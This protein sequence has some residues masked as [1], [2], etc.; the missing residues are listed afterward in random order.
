MGRRKIPRV[1]QLLSEGTY[2]GW[3]SLHSGIPATKRPWNP[4]RRLTAPTLRNVHLPHLH[5]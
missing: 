4:V 2:E 5:Y 1:V 3:S